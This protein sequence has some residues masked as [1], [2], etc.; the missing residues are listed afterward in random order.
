MAAFGTKP[1]NQPAF[2][3][4][5][6]SIVSLT[7]P[8]DV[9]GQALPTGAHGIVVGSYGNGGYEVEFDQP[10]HAVVTLGAHDLTQ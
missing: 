10:F 4:A 7:R 3:F 5:D 1:A 2:A 8:V 6:L 9:D